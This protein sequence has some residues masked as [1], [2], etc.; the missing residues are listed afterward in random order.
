[1][2]PGKSRQVPTG[3]QLARFVLSL[4]AQSNLAASLDAIRSAALRA[5]AQTRCLMP[6]QDNER[7]KTPKA[8]IVRWIPNEIHRT[9]SIGESSPKNLIQLTN[10]PMKNAQAEKID[11]KNIPTSLEI[12]SNKSSANNSEQNK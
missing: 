8:A 11:A 9:S 2:T 12:T 10:I 5:E 7:K 6:D 3:S 4:K 1:M